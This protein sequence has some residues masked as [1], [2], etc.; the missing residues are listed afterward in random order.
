MI[1][2]VR[3]ELSRA[4][5]NNK[6]ILSI[7]LGLILAITHFCV[8]VLPKSQHIY[9]SLDI[10]FPWTVY[11]SNIILDGGSIF[12]HIYY[13]AII[14]LASIPFASSYYTDIQTGFIKNICLK[15]KKSQY[16]LAKYI[17]VFL[18]AGVAGVIPVIINIMLTMTVL[19]SLTPQA[20][21]GVF[22]ILGQVFLAEIYYQNPMFYTLIYIFIEFMFSGVLACM[23]LVFAKIL[24]NEYLVY[25]SPF[26]IYFSAHAVFPLL[27]LQELDFMLLI[28]PISY[29][30][31]TW[32]LITGVFSLLFLISFLPFYREGCVKDVI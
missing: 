25:F 13:Y 24:N 14:L 4:F 15:M 5:Y 31:K 28:T 10:P 17:A 3:F 22:P 32:G 11:D 9:P 30:E 23:A 6:M 26:L 27:A 8:E 12:L 18:S 20:G 19:P 21:A 16:L 1:R 29:Y 2:A 7:L